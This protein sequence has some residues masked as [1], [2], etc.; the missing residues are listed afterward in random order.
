MTIRTIL[1]LLLFGTTSC[2]DSRRKWSDYFEYKFSNSSVYWTEDQGIT[3]D[4]FIGEKGGYGCYDDYFGFTFLWDIGDE[5]KFNVRVYFDKKKSW[6]KPEAEWVNYSVMP[7]SK[8]L[9]YQG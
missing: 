8:R 6:M 2:G 1:I 5:L 3:P 7:K 9:N 4:L